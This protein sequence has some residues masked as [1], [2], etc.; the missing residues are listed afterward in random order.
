MGQARVKKQVRAVWSWITTR[1]HVV[2]TVSGFSPTITRSPVPP[3][4]ES[5]TLHCVSFNSSP[6]RKD[7]GSMQ[8]YLTIPGTDIGSGARLG[9]PV[10]HL[11]VGRMCKDGVRAEL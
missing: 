6:P 9:G 10:S 3:L 7:E 1:G 8:I 2:I 11:N 4:S 5:P